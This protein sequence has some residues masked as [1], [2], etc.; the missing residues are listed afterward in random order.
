M[1]YFDYLLW[2]LNSKVPWIISGFYCSNELCWSGFVLY[3]FNTSISYLFLFHLKLKSLLECKIPFS[4]DSEQAIQHLFI[5]KST[6]LNLSFDSTKW[7]AVHM[8]TLCQFHFFS[9][10]IY[11]LFESYSFSYHNMKEILKWCINRIVFIRWEY[12]CLS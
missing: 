8:A 1:S 4:C 11:S 7:I 10:Q 2:G 3:K 9:Q 5:G 6:S 12:V